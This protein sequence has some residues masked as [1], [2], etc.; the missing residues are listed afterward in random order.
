MKIAL[1]EPIGSHGGMNYYDYGLA[2]GLGENDVLVYYFTCNKTE[3]REY[4][5]VLLYKTFGDIWNKNG[6]IKLFFLLNGYLKSILQSKVKQVDLLHFHFFNLGIIN[7]LVLLFSKITFQK[8]IVTIHDVEPFDG[9][10]N[11]LLTKIAYSLIDGVIVHNFICL[12]EVIQKGLNKN[13]AGVVPIGNHMPFIDS[14]EKRKSFDKFNLLFFG[15]I[16][17]V[18]GLDVLLDALSIITKTQKNIQLTI[19]GKFWKDSKDKYDDQI[20]KLRIGSYI[21]AHYKFIPDEEIVNFFSEADLVVLPYRR[22]Y[23][24]AVLMLTM[25]YG[26]PVLVSDLDAF[27]EIVVD[28]ENGFIFK[29]EDAIDLAN[30]IKLIMNNK[31]DLKKVSEKASDMLVEKYDWVLVGSKTVD[32]YSKIINK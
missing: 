4:K 16:K 19:A 13:K 32:F 8:I 6:L 22:I 11:A 14:L 29:N 1:I 28:N 20:S 31:F 10:S 18:K 17:E 2:L 26:V 30:K 21:D 7:V 24:S 23:Q 12:N 3:C 5:N 9:K 15:Q 27:C 25:S